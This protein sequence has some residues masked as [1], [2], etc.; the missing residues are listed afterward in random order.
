MPCLV[1]L[2][3]R[4]TCFAASWS[5]RAIAK[6]GRATIPPTQSHS[7]PPRCH[8]PPGNDEP[9]RVSEGEGVPSARSPSH[10]VR[11]CSQG[12]GQNG[13]GDVCGVVSRVEGFRCRFLIFG[14][15]RLFAPVA[16]AGVRCACCAWFSEGRAICCCC[17][18]VG[19]CCSFCLLLLLVS[20]SWLTLLL[21]IVML[22]LLV[23]V[24][25]YYCCFFVL[26]CC[27]SCRKYGRDAGGVA[28][29]D[30]RGTDNF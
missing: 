28:S 9:N 10:G 17:F 26:C 7:T 20:M 12:Y 23:L 16:V 21:L 30:S 15:A 25:F 27:C 22:L 24:V 6:R 1:L 11:A 5:P 8:I 4:R 19:G 2:L 18:P 14:V 29:V 13:G 3:P